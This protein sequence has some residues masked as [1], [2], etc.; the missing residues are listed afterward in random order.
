MKR[1]HKVLL[2]YLLFAP[3]PPLVVGA[4]RVEYENLSFWLANVYGLPF[5]PIAELTGSY[6]SG[7]VLY[8]AL[9]AGFVVIWLRLVRRASA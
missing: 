1:W 4:L 5:L 7:A 9:V 6:L 8:W 3:I 2:G